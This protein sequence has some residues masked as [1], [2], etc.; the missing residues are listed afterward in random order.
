MA[1]LRDL[2]R[3]SEARAA[4]L[5]LLST[6]G[7]ALGVAAPA[8]M[9]AALHRCV[10]DIAFFLGQPHG[11][12]SLT[13]EEAGEQLIP[14]HA[15]GKPQQAVAWLEVP[16]VPALDAIGDPEDRDACRLCLNLLGATIDRFAREA[17]RD[18]LLAAL[19]DREQR[20]EALVSRIFSAQ[21]EER[22]RVSH[23]LHDGVAQ[24]MTALVR[25]IEGGGRQAQTGMSRQERERL[26]KIGRGLL[27]DLRAVIGGLRPPLLD[28]LGLAAALQTLADGLTAEG[29]A[30]TLDVDEGAQRLSPHV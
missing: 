5:R 22:R 27:R 17:E 25:M 30:V 3:A 13:Q 7:Q 16:G 11:R 21:E 10:Q 9:D 6:I 18:A 4:R 14:V 2:Y 20:L 23:E 24:T 19:C 15:P 1:D 26:V 12:L 8:T 28:D 29:Y